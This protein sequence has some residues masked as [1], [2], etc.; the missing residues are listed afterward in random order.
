MK[1]KERRGGKA[2]AIAK[3]SKIALAKVNKYYVK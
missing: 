1:Q 2:K 3:I